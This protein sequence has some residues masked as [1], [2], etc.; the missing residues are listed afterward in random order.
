MLD[1]LLTVPNTDSTRPTW[2]MPAMLFV[3]LMTP[4]GAYAIP[5]NMGSFN[6]TSQNIAT[7]SASGNYT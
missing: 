5:S 6:I 7:G 1:H 2:T 3:L 4:L